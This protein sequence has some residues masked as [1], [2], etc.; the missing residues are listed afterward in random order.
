MAVVFLAAVFF[1]G[2]AVP[3]AERAAEAATFGSFFAPLTTSLKLWPAL[4]FGTDVFLIFTAAPV[5][6]LRPVRAGRATFSKTPK[7]VMATR[8]P[9]A[10]ARVTVSMTASTASV[11]AFLL[12][13]WVDSRSIS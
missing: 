11:A 3:V 1:A 5:R 2:A 4:N 9:E 10:T 7:P 8:S 13:S 6:G 12:P